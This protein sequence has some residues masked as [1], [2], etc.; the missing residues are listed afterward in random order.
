MVF[1]SFFNS[2]LG[3][4]IEASP[5]GGILF[6]SFLITLIIT[7]LYKVFTNQEAM[8]AIKDELKEMR[9]EMK[10]FKE[11]PQK[12]MELQKKS[13]KKSMEQ[14]KHSMK[15]ML[16]TMIPLIIIFGW[17][18]SVYAETGALIFGLSWLWIYILSS[19]VF[20]IALR[21]ILKVH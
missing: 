14:M 12:M 13:M 16:I 15:P 6:I 1:D 11:D 17:L 8:K 4:V 20:S 3:G 9:K 21:K 7:L 18:R 2:I 10:E 19:V 5:L